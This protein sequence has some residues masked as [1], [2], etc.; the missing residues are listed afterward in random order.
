M[1][2][3]IEGEPNRNNGNLRGIVESDLEA[4][5]EDPFQ[6]VWLQAEGAPG[7]QEP[8]GDVFCRTHALGKGVFKQTALL[9]QLKN[10]ASAL[11]KIVEDLACCVILTIG[12]FQFE[13]PILLDVEA[14]V[15]NLPSQPPALIG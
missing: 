15:F 4:C 12:V 5:I 11:Q 1:V 13:S 8:E 3:L 9:D 6:V 14:F 2:N 10:Q 7:L